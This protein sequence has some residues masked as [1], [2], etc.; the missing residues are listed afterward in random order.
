MTYYFRDIYL[1]EKLIEAANRGVKISIVLD[2]KPR[3]K[4][5]NDEVY[6]LLKKVAILTLYMLDTK[7][8]INIF[9]E[10]CLRFTRNCTI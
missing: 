1:A 8:P 10:K 6:S 9:R 2:A 4:S 7:H 3:V 5:A